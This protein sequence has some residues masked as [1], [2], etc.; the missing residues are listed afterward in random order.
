MSSPM[1]TE[2]L[3]ALFESD[4]TPDLAWVV[5]KGT[6]TQ[7]LNAPYVLTL[8]LSTNQMDAVPVQMLGQPAKLTLTRGSVMRRVTGIVSEV[9][10]GSTHPEMVTTTIEVVPALEALRHRVNTKIFQ[11]MTVPEILGQVLGESLGAWNRQ[12]DNRLSRTYP[13]CEYRVQYDE[14]DFAFCQRLMEKEGIVYW[15]EFE[16]E[17]ETMVLA[18][19]ESE[20]GAVETLHGGAV[21]YAIQEGQVGGHEYVS[22]L[23]GRSQLVPTKVTTRHFDWTHPSVPIEGE[24]ADAADLGRP[25]GGLLP[26]EREV[27]EQDE[28]PLTLSEYDGAAYGANDVDDQSRLRREAQARE[29]FVCEGRS[30]VLGMTVGSI[31]E[32]SGHPRAELDGRY[33]II[34]A[35]HELDHDGAGYENI[36]ECLPEG[37]PFRT[38]RKMSRPRIASIQTATVVGPSGEEIHTDEHGRIKVQF[39]WDRLG[40]RDEHSSCWVRVMQPWAGAGWGF[41]FIPRIGME[42]VVRFIDGDPDRPIV[43]GSVYNAEHPPPY[44]LPDEKTKSTIKTETS[45]G[46]GGYNEWRFEDKAGSEEIFT[47]AQKDQNEIVEN[48]HTV[49]VHNDETITIDNN[50]VQSIGNDQT[51]HVTN[52]QDLTVDANR[53]IQVHGNFEETIDGSE[54]RTVSSGTT[55]TIDAGET[56]TVT[57]GMTETITGGRTQTI[58]G[59]S[60]ETITGNLNQTIVGGAAINTPAAY[61]ITA[62]GGITVIAPA[63][64]TI[65]SPGGH[66]LIAPGGQTFIDQ[67]QGNS[68]GMLDLVFGEQLSITGLNIGIVPGLTI[69]HTGV[70]LEVTAMI[71]GGAIGTQMTNTPLKNFSAGNN[72]GTEGTEV[73]IDGFRSIL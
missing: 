15:F 31:F 19:A 32:L 64:V 37:V 4:G 29:A 23:N 70:A 46:G 3:D 6:F 48:D 21:E 14:S 68:G 55:E 60:S 9:L 36:C 42:V 33:L 58:N 24:N 35:A 67:Q 61:E 11:E 17:A 69:S 47:H 18:D 54:T 7:T 56:R 57:G 5:Y 2:M 45:L 59:D 44:S 51:E 62:N 16:D 49:T 12:V 72:T 13:T 22:E 25:Q 66:N 26:P 73:D 65:L 10:E 30:T 20:W 41:M 1:D 53:T 63:G 39:H 38:Q 40:V 52:N 34:S 27:Y 8:Q 50:Q 71:K 28:H 43:I